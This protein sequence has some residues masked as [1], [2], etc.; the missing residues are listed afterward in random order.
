MQQGETEIPYVSLVLPAFNEEENIG[1]AV[2]QGIANLLL[3]SKDWEI[4]VVND[5][6]TDSTGSIAEQLAT[7]HRGRMRVLHLKTNS[8]L[9]GALR[10]GFAAARGKLIAYCDSD[11]PFDMEALVR[12]YHKMIEDDVDLVCGFRTNRSDEGLKRLL[13]SRG[14]NMLIRRTFGL[15]V[16]DVN[17]ALKLFKREV[18]DRTKLRSTGSFVDVELQAR[19]KA[20]GF[21]TSEIGVV[22]TPRIHGTSTLAR[23][24]VILDILKEMALFKMGRMPDSPM[25]EV[26]PELEWRPLGSD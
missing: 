4:V 21:R 6:S 24:A 23:P 12:A 9:G 1:E 22:Y 14:Y 25:P 11:L 7:A 17:F 20:A 16:T 5:A 8:G 2:S 19:A 18:L 3:I 13:Y 26:L 15:D 10:V